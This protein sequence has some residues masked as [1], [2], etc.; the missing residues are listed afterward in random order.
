MN[1]DIIKRM[2]EVI[3]YSGLGITDF[4]ATI[5][6][7]QTTIYSQLSGIRSVSLVTIQRIL[8]AFPEIEERWLIL[9]EDQMLSRKSS[10]AQ[11]RNR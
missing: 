4:S 8:I 11:K 7:P 10:V 1:D 3:S 6:I 2:Q 9:G 5:G